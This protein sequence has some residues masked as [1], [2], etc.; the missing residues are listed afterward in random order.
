LLFLGAGS[1]KPFGIGELKDITAKVKEVLIEH[2]YVDVLI[3]I[4]ETLKEANVGSTYFANESE[5][6]I[7]VILSVLD[8]LVEPSTALNT[9]GPSAIF[10]YQSAKKVESSRSF[11]TP[12]KEDYIETRKIV[13]RELV[14]SCNG[15]DFQR[16]LEYYRRLFT[17]ETS[18]TPSYRNTLDQQPRIPLFSHVV[19]TNYDLVLE[20]YDK[21]RISPA[22]HLLRRGFTRGGYDWDEPYL[23]INEVSTAVLE[24]ALSKLEYL[25]LHGSIDWWVRDRDNETVVRDSPISLM[26]ESYHKRQ[27]VYPVYEKHVSEDP[28]SSL[29]SYFRSLLN[30]CHVYVV[31][32]YSFRDR[33]INN[34]FR[35]YLRDKPESRMIIVNRNPD[36]I[37]HRIRNF[38]IMKLDLITAP[39]GSIDLIN[40]LEQVLNR[41]PQ[42]M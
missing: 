31:V 8:L 40:Q 38:S 42:G 13:E 26:G 30:H 34:A 33:S 37:R 15:C 24:S 7:E 9:L 25:K 1:S 14:D 35:D 12:T 6:D 39:F 17:L 21:E 11:K 23:D 16:A 4:H 28:Y 22:K 32:G 29:F 10:I 5:I 36:N 2:G 18:I 3:N 20:R 41:P 19:T 27:M